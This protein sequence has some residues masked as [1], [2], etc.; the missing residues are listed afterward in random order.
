MQE[1]EKARGRKGLYK[2]EERTTSAK[3]KSGTTVLLF[4]HPAPW[5]LWSPWSILIH[6]G[7]QF[8]ECGY[9][10]WTK[11]VQGGPGVVQGLRQDHGAGWWTRSVQ[12]HRGALKNFFL[13]YSSCFLL[14]RVVI[15]PTSLK[16]AVK[17][18]NLNVQRPSVPVQ[19]STAVQL[20]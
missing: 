10:K 18:P 17:H 1:K 11:Q 7:P 12:D 14:S 4:H 15:I 16:E 8:P 13:M 9:T 20:P 2:K 5:S 6:L 19:K 3:C